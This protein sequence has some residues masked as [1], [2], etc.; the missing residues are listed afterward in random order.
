[1]EW[2]I[3]LF[4]F[5]CTLAMISEIHKGY[6]EREMVKAKHFKETIYA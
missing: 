6:H 5:I 1:M 2:F 3:G 4:A